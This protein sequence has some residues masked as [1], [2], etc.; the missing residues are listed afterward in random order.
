M[1]LAITYRQPGFSPSEAEEILSRRFGG[2]GNVRPLPSE[3]DQNFLVR[4]ADGRRAVLK[5]SHAGEERG[6]LELQHQALKRLAERAPGVAVPRVLPATDGSEI[7]ETTGSEGESHYIRLLSW[8]NGAMLAEIRP[9]TPE[10]LESLGR[11]IGQVDVGLGDSSTRRRG[12][13]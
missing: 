4:F 5:I 11:V 7:L 6:I 8:I 12:G 10:L 9:H 13:R 2:A 1:T 3:R